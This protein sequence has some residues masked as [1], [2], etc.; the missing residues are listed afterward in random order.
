MGLRPLVVRPRLFTRVGNEVELK[1]VWAWYVCEQVLCD[2]DLGS[3][4][5]R[6][7][8]ILGPS[9]SGK[10]TL[11]RWLNR[12]VDSHPL[13]RTQGDM[14]VDGIPVSAKRSGAVRLRRRF[15]VIAQ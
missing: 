2:V 1:S 12:M 5:H 15:G 14:L 3:P 6:L 9:K 7:T 11:L 10:F 13:G 4:K 8:V